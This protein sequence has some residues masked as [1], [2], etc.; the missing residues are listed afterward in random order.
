MNSFELIL[1]KHKT[2]L[3]NIARSWE[4][5]KYLR[6]YDL[7][8][9]DDIYQECLIA[10]MDA[11]K[12]YDKEISLSSFKTYV[13]RV[14]RNHMIDLSLHQRS[15]VSGQRGDVVWQED[16]VYVDDFEEAPDTLAPTDVRKDVDRTL[17]KL[18]TE[19]ER[20]LYEMYYVH[21]LSQEEI[22][23]ILGVSQ[24]TVS[25]KLGKLL[26]IPELRFLLSAYS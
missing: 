25:K 9:S 13:E 11:Y 5:N 14:V 4:G 16:L 15:K 1:K 17:N 10:F 7:H 23:D 2:Q 6:A 18:L 22:K 26:L 20:Q 8:D 3:R 21:G 12:T 19:E 24:K